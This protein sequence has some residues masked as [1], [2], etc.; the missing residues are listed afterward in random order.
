MFYSAVSQGELLDVSP[1]LNQWK[2]EYER[3]AK[4]CRLFIH[5]AVEE[6]L[7]S[8]IEDVRLHVRG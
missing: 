8:K 7:G 6:E 1:I 5:P 4:T 3:H 2:A